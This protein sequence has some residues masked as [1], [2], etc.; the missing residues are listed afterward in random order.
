MIKQYDKKPCEKCKWWINIP[1]VHSGCD[2]F[3]MIK[4]Q[5][6]GGEKDNSYIYFEPIT[7]PERCS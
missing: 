6:E 5:C 1:G 3:E 4:N 7:N 2:N